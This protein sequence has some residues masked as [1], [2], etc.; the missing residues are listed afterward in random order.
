MNSCVAVGKGMHMEQKKSDTNRKYLRTQLTGQVFGNYI[1]A[2][3]ICVSSI[4]NIGNRLV[5]KHQHLMAA[6]Q[7]LLF[8]AV[9]KR[10]DHCH[11]EY[12]DPDRMDCYYFAVYDT[13]AALSG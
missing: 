1:L 3:V 6:E 2:L 4:R 11:Y 7:H 5:S 12:I 10:M 8:V 9:G 13:P